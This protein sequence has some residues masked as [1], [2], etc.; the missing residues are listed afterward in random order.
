MIDPV[1]VRRPFI[2]ELLE[3]PEV[4]LVLKITGVALGAI[5]L[6]VGISVPLSYALPLAPLPVILSLRI[7]V[8]LIFLGSV[9]LIDLAFKDFKQQKALKNPLI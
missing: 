8:I 3:K 1:Q 5:A 2:Q 7:S 9:E 6:I 4:Q